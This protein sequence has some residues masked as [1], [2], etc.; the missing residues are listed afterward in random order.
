MRCGV[1][2]AKSPLYGTTYHA[3]RGRN[4]ANGK[5]SS[6]FAL[7]PPS[8]ALFFRNSPFR[9]GRGA[10]KG[11]F[12][13]S[14]SIHPPPCRQPQ[15]FFSSLTCHRKVHLPELSPFPKKSHRGL[16][17][18]TRRGVNSKTFI[19]QTTKRQTESPPPK[20]KK[21]QKVYRGNFHA[22]SLTK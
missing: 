4:R 10:F 17:M 8:L 19:T 7:P 3:A 18:S 21:N 16:N 15:G 13:F 5:L 1:N 20:K 22:C 11:T 6:F 14:R 12:F 2:G 9:Q